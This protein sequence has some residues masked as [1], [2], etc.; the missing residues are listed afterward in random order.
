M[1]PDSL[2]R[3]AKTDYEQE[4]QHTNCTDKLHILYQ[5][6]HLVSEEWCL[7]GRMRV[8]SETEYRPIGAR[9]VSLRK[10]V[11]KSV[12]DSGYAHV[13]QCF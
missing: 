5:T 3:I 8:P 4:C 10:N 6:K 11:G 1:H 9:L 2:D 12:T 13:T 7:Y